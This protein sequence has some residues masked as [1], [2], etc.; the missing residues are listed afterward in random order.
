MDSRIMSMIENKDSSFLIAMNDRA[1]V[2]NA[3]SNSSWSHAK[4]ATSTNDHHR[5]NPT[6]H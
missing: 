1:N 2:L 3:S 5:K 6:Y 4:S